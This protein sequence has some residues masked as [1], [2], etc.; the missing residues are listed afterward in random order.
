MDFDIIDALSDDE[1]N[2][3][4]QR[5]MDEEILVSDC[6]GGTCA[7][8]TKGAGRSCW[9]YC[10]YFPYCR[11]EFNRSQ[12]GCVIYSYISAWASDCRAAGLPS[13]FA[14]SNQISYVCN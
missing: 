9:K 8:G 7:E 13:I 14:S 3:L 6:L 10:S 12:G 2:E 5:N 4:Y 1:V 11:Y